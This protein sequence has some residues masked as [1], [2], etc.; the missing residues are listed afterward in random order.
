[1]ENCEAISDVAS[2]IRRVSQDFADKKIESFII[3]VILGDH[4]NSNI[5]NFKNAVKYSQYL[6]EKDNYD[7]LLQSFNST[8]K[9]I[10]TKKSG[11]SIIVEF[12]DAH[13][14]SNGQRD[15]LNFVSMLLHAQRKLHKINNILIIDEVFDYLDD[16]NLIAAQYYITKFIKEM[17]DECKNIYPILLTHLNPRY[18]INYAFKK[19]KIVFID[20]RSGYQANENFEKLLKK[21][22]EVDCNKKKTLFAKNLEKYFLHYN[23]DTF[24]FETEFQTARLPQTWGRDSGKKFVEFINSEANKYK[25]GRTDYDPLAVCC[26][27]RRKIEEK[28]YAMLI[29]TDSQQEFIKKHGTSNK[30]KYVESLNIEVPERYYMLGIIYNEGLHWYENQDNYSPI[31]SKFEHL[32]IK[33]L[34]IKALE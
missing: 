19:P 33:E 34:V 5:D 16:A 10:R 23:P 14:I 29:N 26:A 13:H 28:L 8:W 17:E 30:L 32:T 20:K 9:E 6:I 11:K 15:I 3:A 25:I 27:V 21:R 12:P 7:K 22:N 4:Y 24:D 31:A 2:F 18:F 1:M